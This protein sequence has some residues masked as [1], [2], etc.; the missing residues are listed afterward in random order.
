MQSP[1]EPRKR[2]WKHSP[3]TAA[4]RC[5]AA[6]AGSGQAE[7]GARPQADRWVQRKGKTSHPSALPQSQWSAFQNMSPK[8]RRIKQGNPWPQCQRAFQAS[9]ESS[10]WISWPEGSCSQLQPPALLL[11]PK[12][13]PSVPGLAKL[14][15][16]LLVESPWKGDL[17]SLAPKWATWRLGE[18]NRPESEG[19]RNS[20]VWTT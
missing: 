13:I 7:A 19:G 3:G 11:Q 4:G 16:L 12:A 18:L 15:C 20:C 8:T 5:R 17:T 2:R 9:H 14:A 6:W 10:L 1:A